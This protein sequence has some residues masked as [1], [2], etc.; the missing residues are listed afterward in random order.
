[1]KIEKKLRKQLHT[2]INEVKTTQ[3]LIVDYAK[4]MDNAQ[5]AAEC[6]QVFQYM[7]QV[8]E[9]C[10][11]FEMYVRLVEQRGVKAFEKEELAEELKTVNEV[12]ASNEIIEQQSSEFNT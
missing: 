9:I 8:H 3:E 4:K 11:G 1:M 5:L 12:E 10:L 7:G 6:H 2:L